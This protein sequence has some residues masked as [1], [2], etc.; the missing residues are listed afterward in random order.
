MPSRGTPQSPTPLDVDG[1]ERGVQGGF[2]HCN[3]Y[4]LLFSYGNLEHALIQ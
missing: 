4:L 1:G 2:G 3:Y